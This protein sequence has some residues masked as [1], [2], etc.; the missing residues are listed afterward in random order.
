M[1]RLA[2]EVELAAYRIAQE[3]VNNAVEHARA[4]NIVIRVHCG[5][6]KLTLTVTDDGIGFDLPPRPDSL[7]QVG[8]FGLLGM[9]E[10]AILLGGSVRLISEPGKG[11]QVI[12]QL[13]DCQ[14]DA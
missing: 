12:A 5:Q 11:T 10:R 14:S 6:D 9:H 7:T 3:A 4:K 2:P 1:R 8:R 13:P